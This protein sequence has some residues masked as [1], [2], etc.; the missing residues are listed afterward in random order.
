MAR[1]KHRDEPELPLFDLPLRPAEEPAAT[2]A[3]TAEAPVAEA[4]IAEPSPG[5]PSPGEPPADD[6]PAGGP[7]AQLTLVTTAEPDTEAT[8]DDEAGEDA[9]VP[10]VD[11]LRSGLADLAVQLLMLAVAVAASLRL[12]VELTAAD[13]PSFVLLGLVFSFFYWVVPLAFWGQ[14]PGMVWVGHV[15]RSVDEEPLTVGQAILRW[16][17]AVLTTALAGLPLLLALLSGRSLSDR[18]SESRTRS[19]HSP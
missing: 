9:P 1:R 2:E 11:R 6:P 14:T 15:A 12:G 10:L 17:G 18:V 16:V 19:A 8:E 5:E 3:P 13:W 7:P 4:P